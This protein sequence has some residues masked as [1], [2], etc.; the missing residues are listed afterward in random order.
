MQ[1]GASLA[2]VK[3]A[4]CAKPGCKGRIL[5]RHHK[6]H[7]AIWLGIWASK[8]RTEAKWK[9]FVH[10]YHAFLEADC[11][12]I[13]DVHHAEIH[14][15]YDVIIQQDQDRT[16]RRLEDYTWKQA[17]KLMAKLVSVCD[18]WLQVESKGLSSRVYDKHKRQPHMLDRGQYL[19]NRIDEY[20][21]HRANSFN[22]RVS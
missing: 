19:L 8:R 1:L 9:K 6:R 10:D 3:T 11:V 17:D 13:C 16:K 18:R 12:R 14:M 21:L 4:G 20:F 22:E 15:L 7:Q 2:E 5:Q